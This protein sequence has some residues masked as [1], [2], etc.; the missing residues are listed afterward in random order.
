[1]SRENRLAIASKKGVPDFTPELPD[2]PLIGQDPI[3]RD[4]LIHLLVNGERASYRSPSFA[5]KLARTRSIL[6]SDLAFK[7]LPV[8]ID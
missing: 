3:S 2:P 7:Y 8:Q 5:P 1:M 6:L 4:F